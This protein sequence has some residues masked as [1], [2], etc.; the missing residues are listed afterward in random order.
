MYY[1]YNC[2]HNIGLLALWFI[3]VI[4]FRNDNSAILMKF[5]SY[6]RD[7]FI[8]ELSS[9]ANF[10]SLNKSLCLENAGKLKLILNISQLAYGLLLFSALFVKASSVMKLS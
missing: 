7:L 6:F 1:F 8:W 9:L 5:D 3:Y 10:E 2:C 4:G